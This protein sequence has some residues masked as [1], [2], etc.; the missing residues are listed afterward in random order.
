MHLSKLETVR[1]QLLFA[2]CDAETP[3]A[4]KV[5]QPMMWA[6]TATALALGLPASVCAPPGSLPAFLLRES[7]MGIKMPP[8]L[9]VVEGMAGAMRASAK[10]RP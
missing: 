2:L 7:M 9:A 5:K 3:Q 6:V 8:A 4:T 1:E 10:L